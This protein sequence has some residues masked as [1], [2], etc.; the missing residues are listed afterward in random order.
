VKAICDAVRS[1]TV[2]EFQYDG[3][4]RVVTP[5]CH[6]I[7]ERGVEVLR[8]VQ[9]GGES[10]SRG[11]GFGKLWI[12]QRMQQARATGAAFVPDDPD[13]NPDDSAMRTIC[14]RVARRR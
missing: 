1:C 14:C 8:A 11:F 13:Y 4:R 7:N 3:L 6:G 9:I 12:V 5:Y 2:L 10:R